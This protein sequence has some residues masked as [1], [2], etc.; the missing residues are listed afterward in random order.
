MTTQSV[1]RHLPEVTPSFFAEFLNHLSPDHLSLLDQ[2][3]CVGLRYGK[4]C[5]FYPYGYIMKLFLETETFQIIPCCQGTFHHNS[6]NQNNG[7]ANYPYL[8]A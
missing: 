2:P 4:I 6:I 5:V 7:F 8:I 3:T 1:V